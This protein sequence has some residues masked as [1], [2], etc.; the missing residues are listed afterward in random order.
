MV[1]DGVGQGEVVVPGR[2]DIPVLDQRVVQV[3][4]KCLLHVGHIL[5]LCD[6]PHGNLLPFVQVA[7][8]G[9]HG[10]GGGDVLLLS[11]SGALH[12]LASRRRYSTLPSLS[13]PHSLMDKSRSPPRMRP[14]RLAVPQH[15]KLRPSPL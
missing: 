11:P 8:R 9:G 3:A 4:I 5:H 13:L 12:W 1:P 6:A 2:G 10:G 7:L 15:S 14:P